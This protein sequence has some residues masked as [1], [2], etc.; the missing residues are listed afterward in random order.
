MLRFGLNSRKIRKRIF[1]L[2]RLE[3][4][5]D[6]VLEEGPWEGVPEKYV[7]LVAPGKGQG[8]NVPAALV[9]LQGLSPRTIL[10]IS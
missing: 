3:H 5:W 2:R 9:V 4:V 10:N 8:L 1:F 7:Q 6:L